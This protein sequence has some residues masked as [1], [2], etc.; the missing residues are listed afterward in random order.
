[1][2][3]SDGH[4]LAIPDLISMCYNPSNRKRSNAKQQNFLKIL[5]FSYTCIWTLCWRFGNEFKYSSSKRFFLITAVAEFNAKLL[6]WMKQNRQFAMIPVIKEP[7]D[8]LDISSS[9]SDRTFIYQPNII[10]ES[11]F[12]NFKFKLENSVVSLLS[13]LS[14]EKFCYT[15][16]KCSDKD[17][18]WIYIKN[19]SLKKKNIPCI[20]FCKKF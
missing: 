3:H 5:K 20:I 9:S 10:V 7:T 15:R 17:Y 14:W 11:R 13:V 12:F 4:I 6:H 19:I 1:M 16:N 2:I 8:I 18:P